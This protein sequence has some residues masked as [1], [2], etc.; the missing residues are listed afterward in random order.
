MDA[1]NTKYSA[2]QSAS[3]KKEDLKKSGCK[4]HYS[5]RQLP[6]HDRFNTHVD[7]MY[8]I[9]N[10]A[11]HIVGLISGSQDSFKVRHEERQRN[12]FPTSWVDSD[13]SQLP[14]APFRLEKEELQL[15]NERALQIQVPHSFDCKARSFFQQKLTGMKSHEWKQ[16]ITSEILSFAFVDY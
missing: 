6:G 12:H 15:A 5:L 16:L 3:C 11:E 14:P 13:S 8:L 4:G 7:P 1:A 10:I 9:K 2:T